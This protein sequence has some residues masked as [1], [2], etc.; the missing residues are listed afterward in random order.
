MHIGAAYRHLDG[1]N[2]TV[3]ATGG[4]NWKEFLPPGFQKISFFPELWNEEEH[5]EWG[6]EWV[7][8]MFNIENKN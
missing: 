7:N 2:K 8:H 5:E 3:R 1:R 4:T 6:K